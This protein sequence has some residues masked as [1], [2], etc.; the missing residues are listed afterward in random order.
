MWWVALTLGFFG[1]LHCLGMCGP[2]ALAFCD[3]QGQNTTQQLVTGISYN[4]GRTITYGLMGLV[5]GL[6]GS[7]LFMA[8]MQKVLSIVLGVLLILF[9][10]FSIDLDKKISSTGIFSKFY[11][12]LQSNL[13]TL[14]KKSNGYNPLYLGMLNGFLPCGLVYLALTGALSTGHLISG[15]SFMFYFGLGTTPMLLSLTMGQHWLKP[16]LRHRIR[17][18]IPYVTLAFGIFLLYRGL[19]VDI[20]KELDFWQAMRNPIMCH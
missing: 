7:F 14:L 4:L 13:S 12:Y 15:M 19:A 8:D 18:I 9:F 6:L 16:K 17:R 3:R 20:P 1:S 5:F 10:L 11:Q 2:L